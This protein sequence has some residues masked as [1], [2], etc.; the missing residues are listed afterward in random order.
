[1]ILY[2]E[3]LIT[4]VYNFNSIQ[5]FLLWFT[6]EEYNL[7]HLDLHNPKYEYGHT[8]NADEF[9][10]LRRAVLFYCGEHAFIFQWT[11]INCRAMLIKKIIFFI[12]K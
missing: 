3:S 12:F 9:K 4:F 8:F 2:L 5:L 10:I 1:M 6:F 7:N 11:N